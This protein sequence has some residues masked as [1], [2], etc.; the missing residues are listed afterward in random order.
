MAEA[1]LGDGGGGDGAVPAGVAVAM[2]TYTIVLVS[3]SYSRRTWGAQGDIGEG[4]CATV[5]WW[6]HLDRLEE[7]RAC[8]RDDLLALQ[9][10]LRL[11]R[12]VELDRPG[13][14]ARDRAF[15]WPSSV[16]PI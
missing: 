1:R 3:S 4:S 15:G 7:Q 8:L 14:H 6:A 9:R 11:D 10:V 13:L 12:R 16:V 2:E 5:Q